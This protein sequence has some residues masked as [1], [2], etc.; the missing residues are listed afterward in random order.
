VGTALTAS[1][2]MPVMLQ[3]CVDAAVKDLDAAVARLWILSE[4][5]DLLVPHASASADGLD[6]TDPSAVR[7]TDPGVGALAR[8]MTADVTDPR[9]IEPVAGDGEWCRRAGVTTFAGYPLIVD[10][11]LVGFFGLYAHNPWSPDALDAISSASRKIALGIE[12]RLV[13]ARLRQNEE[14]TQFALSSARMG[15]W[16][17]DLARNEMV[18]ADTLRAVFGIG[19]EDGPT[20][21]QSFQERIHPDDRP[22]VLRELE[23]AVAAHRDY[24]VTF[25]VTWPD[26]SVHWIDGHGHLLYD[27]TGQPA[28]VV[29]VSIDVSERKALESQLLQAQKMEGIGLLAGGVAH[30]FNNL[31]TAILG[32][33]MLL[34]ESLPPESPGCRDVEEIIKAT[35]RAAGLTRQL[36]A[37]SRKQVF[38]PS[39]V[40]LNTLIRDMSPMLGLLMGEDVSLVMALASSLAPVRADAGQLQQVVM[41]LAMNARDAMP[42]GG[43]L[44]IETANVE[45]DDA[46]L[47]HHAVAAPG[48]YVRVVVSDTGVGI[49]QEIKAHL[50]EPFFTTK[51]KGRGT[52]LGLAT[53]YGIVQQ[54][55]GYIWVYSE[56]RQGAT[57]K[58]YLP[59]SDDQVD[60]PQRPEEAAASTGS[61]LVVV[62]EDEEAVRRLASLV[63]RRAGYRV[64]EAAGAKEAEALVSAGREPFDLLVSD[65][66]MPEMSGPALYER[67]AAR[68]P[69]LK[70]LYMSGYTDDAIIR[71]GRLQAGAAFL[72][73]PFTGEM[74]LR[75]IREVSGP[76]T[77]A[78]QPIPRPTSAGRF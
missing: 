13:E 70:V 7:M 1:A 35:E 63:L 69:A 52:G 12:R 56:P 29:G 57:F 50:F 23:R 32:Y 2:T 68:Q 42:G 66:V 58:V 18:S 33:S 25:R 10:G 77:L 40:H 78:S 3:A 76:M 53:V 15:I 60:E 19:A 47:L 8:T 20:D 38:E 34:S 64:L 48:R 45:L 17:M 74:L 11:R 6:P 24:A 55:G 61:E 14:R 46:Y 9:E 27:D 43:Q 21:R 5:G 30:D 59:A 22:M 65:V 31:L 72:Q 37:F 54:S 36:L 73:K 4:A 49:P 67:L 75:K 44:L 39:T 51:E 16:E 71:Q 28:R 26:G 62:V 41:N